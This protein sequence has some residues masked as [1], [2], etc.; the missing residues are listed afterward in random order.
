[1][2]EL[3][4]FHAQRFNRPEF[5]LTDPVQFPRRFTD[6]RDVEITALLIST[7]AWG[8]R[9]MILRDADRLLTLLDNEP[10]R[11][12][13]E[14]NIKSIQPE[15]NIHRTFFGANLHNYL[16]ALRNIYTKHGTLQNFVHSKALHLGEDPSWQL[17]KVLGQEIAHAAGGNPDPRCLPVNTEASALKR[18]NMAL[19]WLV[20]NDGIVDMGVWDVLKPSQL[21]IPLDV[22]VA[23][24]SRKLG[25]LE[26]RSNDKKAVVQLTQALKRFNADDPVLYDFALF[27]LG[28]SR[29]IEKIG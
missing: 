3:L 1:M 18:L 2:K 27:S 23:N 21:F 5:A 19:R 6:L 7:I 9:K 26:R 10:F 13:S 11:F 20:R 25:L 22:H 24:T 16:K 29:E 15:M 28:E 8:N 14:G 17:G 4:D 12:V